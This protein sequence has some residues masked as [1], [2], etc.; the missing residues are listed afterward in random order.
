MP[1]CTV[2]VSSVGCFLFLVY[3]FHRCFSLFLPLGFGGLQ[4]NTKMKKVILCIR[5]GRMCGAEKNAAVSPK[6]PARFGGKTEPVAWSV[7]RTGAPCV[8]ADEAGSHQHSALVGGERERKIDY[9]PNPSDRTARSPRG[10]EGG[11]AA[12]APR[13]KSCGTR[14]L[15]QKN[16]HTHT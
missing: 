2:L 11:A 8:I 7:A 15:K 4:A 1:R 16:T 3:L 13:T 10:A 5:Y 6:V 12:A 9:L 14:N